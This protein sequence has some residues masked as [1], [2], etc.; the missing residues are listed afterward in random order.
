MNPS[1]PPR[2]NA[3][4]PRVCPGA[5]VRPSARLRHVGTVSCTLT[6]NFDIFEVDG[7]FKTPPAQLDAA[8]EPATPPAADTPRVCPGAPKKRS[9]TPA[10][11]P[12]QPLRKCPG[13]PK[14]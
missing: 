8:I 11:P 10:T 7:E 3:D 12:R 5:P 6:F 2:I 13:A 14:K 4:A 9:R 1:T